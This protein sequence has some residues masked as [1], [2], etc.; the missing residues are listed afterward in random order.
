MAT[1]HND[2][3][4]VAGALSIWGRRPL[5]LVHMS[6]ALVTG[7]TSGIG[8]AFATELAAQGHDLVLV[9]RDQSRLDVT[10]ADLRARF[11]HEVETIAADLGVRSDL[12][13]II[14]RLTDPARPVDVLVNNA[15]FGLNASLLA[16][17]TETQERAMAVMCTA[18]LI[19]AGAA[20]RA[21]KA[22]GSGTIINVASVAAWIVKGNYSAI[23]RWVVTYTQA[24]AL[25]LDG[26][27]V[28]ATAVC[29][30]WVKTELHARAGVK[31]PKL[32]GWA[33]VSPAQVARSALDAAARGKVVAVP[34]RRW[35]T[36]VWLLEHAPAA[37]PR[38]VS[39]K[40]SKSRS[41]I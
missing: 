4:H 19:L 14:A 27:G 16:E 30:G 8:L 13:P 37:L 39:R 3:F 40:I 2:P 23:K 22:R 7:G 20:G 38:L 15:G 6:T 29:P 10:A 24:L 18:V 33:W 28:Q 36:A 9:A 21:M 5:L 12:E 26:T 17:A 11:G 25:E 41:G 35:Q 32:P 1:E 31:R 34:T